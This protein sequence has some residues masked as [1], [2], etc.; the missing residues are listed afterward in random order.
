M[1]KFNSEIYTRDDL[2]RAMRDFIENA[3]P[4]LVNENSGYD[5]GESLAHHTP[6]GT[7]LEGWSRMLWGLVP[8]LAGGYEYEHLDDFI[9]GFR[10]GPELYWGAPQDR[11]RDL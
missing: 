7:L 11:T 2:A 8:Y 5:F 4:F 9:E 10:K 3:R 6:E 1:W